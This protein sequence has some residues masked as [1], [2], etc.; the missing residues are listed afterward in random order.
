MPLILEDELNELFGDAPPLQL[1]P[2]LPKGQS[3]RIDELCLS[4]CRQYVTEPKSNGLIYLK[5]SRKITWSKGGCIAYISGDNCNIILK[6]L[7]C[8]SY[9]GQW[10]LS[11]G[12]SL[13]DLP[14]V[15]DGGDIVHLSWSHS[16]SELAVVDLLG[17]ISVFSIFITMN[18]LNSSRRCILDPEDH[19][20]A[21]VGLMW[22][23]TTPAHNSPE[24]PV[25]MDSV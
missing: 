2:S 21:V 23:H 16:G 11:K 25:S 17:R 13:D 10:K 24:R 1:P 7:I 19:L 3:Q 18:R 5:I 4:G 14:P 15:H 12:Y 9:D 22:L 6:H 20:G 8:D